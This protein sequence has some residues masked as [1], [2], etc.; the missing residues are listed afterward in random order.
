LVLGA[1][2]EEKGRRMDRDVVV[3]A[4]RQ[5]SPL[6]EGGLDP[7]RGSWKLESGIW[8]LETGIWKLES[9]IRRL[10]MP[11]PTSLENI[12]SAMLRPGAEGMMLAGLRWL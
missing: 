10:K 8:K 7:A 1:A 4:A 9:R 3:V 6:A 11:G 2:V 12:S 5:L